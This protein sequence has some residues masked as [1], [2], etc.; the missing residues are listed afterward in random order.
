MKSILFAVL[1]TFPV[2]AV[3]QS[4]VSITC[5]SPASCGPTTL[6]SNI[7]AASGTGGAGAMSMTAGVAPSTPAVGLTAS[8]IT[9]FAPLTV[10][11]AYGVAPSGTAATGLWYG[12]LGSGA[13]FSS[14]NVTVTGGVIMGF[15]G[16]FSGGS[17]YFT[18]PPC[19]F[20]TTGSYT[21]VGTC[22]FSVSGGTIST[23]NIAG[24]GTGSGYT[25][26][27]V[28]VNWAPAIN[29][30]YTPV[31]DQTNLLTSSGNPNSG[32]TLPVLSGTPANGNLGSFFVSSGN[33]DLVDSTIAATNVTLLTANN[34]FT[35]NNT[36]PSTGFALSG[37]STAGHY[38]R[39]NG[40][41]YVDSLILASD[42][43]FGTPGPIGTSSPSTGAFTTITGT[44]SLT[45]GVNG[46]T[47]G[48]VVMEGSTSGSATLIT[49]LT[50]TTIGASTQV[51]VPDNKG[52]VISQGTGSTGGNAVTYG[53][54]GTGTTE[55]ADITGG[56]STNLINT[57]NKCT[58]ALT[59]STFT[60]ALSPVSI[61]TF[62]LPNVANTWT[63]QCSMEW[64]NNA[65][66]SPTFAIGVTWA[67]APSA[68]F[69]MET[70]YSAN[71]SAPAKQIST[72]TTTNATIGA[73]AALTPATLFQ[74]FASGNFTASATSGVFSPTVIL[75][76][77]GATGTATGQCM[78]L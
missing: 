64:S 67:H 69:Q 38:L 33:Y 78:L 22:T 61:C 32:Y 77:T 18:P 50:A 4:T 57:G 11:A 21:T 76:G 65:G 34:S 53:A 36:F 24:G 48:S 41:D 16:S 42:V 46:G 62:T 58:F 51:E 25:P 68:A 72:T 30:S 26:G 56:T 20:T 71:A 8:S 73:T 29:L 74:A 60:L 13:S 35:G 17:G 40:T 14:Y 19:F 15:T 47:V 2:C 28:S 12:T 37:A 49:N 23:V 44:S 52:F 75:T 39:N 63:W 7:L 43:P 6:Q 31:S 9:L 55:A 27:T 5:T 70:I 10:T 54:I 45:L 1:L 66:T 59:T 3:C